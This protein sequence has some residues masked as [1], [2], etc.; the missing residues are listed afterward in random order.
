MV[1]VIVL[2]YNHEHYVEKCLQNILAQSYLDLEVVVFDD[3][4]SDESWK[5][6]DSFQHKDSRI[7]ACRNKKNVGP[8]RNFERALNTCRGGL[9]AICEG[10]DFWVSPR[11]I[12]LQVEAISR[13]PSVGLVYADYSKSDENG[14]LIQGNVLDSQPLVFKLEN[15]NCRAVKNPREFCIGFWIYINHP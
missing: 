6:I 11:K 2:V 10:D 12:E 5:I 8:A 13:D 7:F 4:S 14:E 15:I 1:S 9:I 3:H